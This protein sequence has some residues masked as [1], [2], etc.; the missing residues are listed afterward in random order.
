MHFLVL[1]ELECGAHDSEV[2][3]ELVVV[4]RCTG[5]K[6]G[7]DRLS[8]AEL[9]LPEQNVA[10]HCEGIFGKSGIAHGSEHGVDVGE[11]NVVVASLIFVSGNIVSGFSQICAI[12]EIL[13]IVAHLVD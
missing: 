2:G 1:L 9:L 8:L 13:H 11:G 4:R 12:G 3:I 5:G 10:L 7:I 6:V